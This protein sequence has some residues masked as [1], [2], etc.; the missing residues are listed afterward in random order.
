MCV[1]AWLSEFCRGN[2]IFH[3]PQF[4]AAW[5]PLNHCKSLMLFPVSA[6]DADM[7]LASHR[8]ALERLLKMP[9]R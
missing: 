2:L 8:A 9:P 3:D 7:T 5:L 4:F 1:T 6:I